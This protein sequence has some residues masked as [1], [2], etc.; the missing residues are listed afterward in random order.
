[1]PFDPISS[2]LTKAK[3]PNCSTEIHWGITTRYDSKQ[4]AEICNVC[5]TVLGKE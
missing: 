5:K 2:F 1:M 4:D 3:C